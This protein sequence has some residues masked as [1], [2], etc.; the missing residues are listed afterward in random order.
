MV[1]QKTIKLAD[2]GLSKRIDEASKL[3]S[4]VFGVIPYVDP[5]R[6]NKAKGESVLQQLKKLSDVYSIGVLF[7][8]LSSRHRP[9]ENR[10]YDVYLAIDIREGLRETPV[11]GTPQDYIKLYTG[12][13]IKIYYIIKYC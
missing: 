5:K 6:L 8:E 13:L 2:F 4:K 9:F 12:K 10:D 1:H 11:P 7:W 3:H